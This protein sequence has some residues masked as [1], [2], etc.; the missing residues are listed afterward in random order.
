M[1]PVSMYSGKGKISDAYKDLIENLL[2]VDAHTHIGRDTDGH[3][4]SANRLLS[5][6]DYFGVNMAIAFPLNNPRDNHT[7]SKSNDYIINASKK[8]KERIIPF[9]RLNPRF[10]EWKNEI[11]RCAELGFRG[12]KLHPRSQDFIINGEEAKEVYAAAE[13]KNMAVIVHCGLAVDNA[14]EKLES[15]AKEFKKLKF[16]IGHAG[17]VDMENMIKRST[18]MKNFVFETSTVNVFDLF[19]LMDGV[20]NK[21]IVF[22]SDVPYWDMGVSLEMNIQTALSLKKSATS[23]RGMLGGNILKWFQ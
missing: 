11:V 18:H 6:M 23:I 3:S 21:Q 20:D 15:I 22:G 12:I 10:E 19:E 5:D 17:F 2:I 16:I 7:F 4:I 1:P 9:C 8:A 14:A 13:E